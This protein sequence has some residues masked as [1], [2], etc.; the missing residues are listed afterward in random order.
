MQ[1]AT[2]KLCFSRPELQLELRMTFPTKQNLRR[3][4]VLTKTR[5]LVVYACVIFGTYSNFG[6]MTDFIQ[7]LVLVN[8]SCMFLVSASSFGLWTS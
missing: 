3:V 4:N 1:K 7:I 6:F 2:K 8:L 5:Y